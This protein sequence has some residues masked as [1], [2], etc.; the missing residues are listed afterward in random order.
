A[1]RPRAD[2]RSLISAT[3]QVLEPRR[4]F[5]AAGPSLSTLIS[6]INN[7]SEMF[8]RTAGT[9]A[10]VDPED[11]L[12]QLY[13]PPTRMLEN[14]GGFLTARQDGDPLDIA[15]S[16]MTSRAADLGLSGAD[17]ANAVVTDQYTDAPS[18]VTHIYLRQTYNGLPIVGAEMGVHV[19]PDGR[20]LSATSSF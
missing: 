12:T 19:M 7:P 6:S 3:F 16:Y 11:G 5:S 14:L 20:I 10:G 18:G 4:L 2:R 15:R 1:R 8:T 17:I 9:T 13:T